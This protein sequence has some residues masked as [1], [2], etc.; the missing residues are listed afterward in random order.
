[1]SCSSGEC[2]FNT[3]KSWATWALRTIINI[4]TDI[5]YVCV[6]WDVHIYVH[7]GWLHNIYTHLFS[8]KY[9]PVVMHHLFLFRKQGQV[10][11]WRAAFCH[12]LSIFYVNV[13]LIYA[14]L[15]V[16]YIFLFV[17]LFVM[18]FIVIYFY[19]CFLTQLDHFTSR[20]Y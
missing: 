15:D 9:M 18:N 8:Q 14:K 19:F 2:R 12:G 3:F 6:C 4:R 16:F 11:F 10:N 5:W 13:L 7:E 17:C 20:M 1:M